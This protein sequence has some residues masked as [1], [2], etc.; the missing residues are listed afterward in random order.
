MQVIFEL[1]ISRFKRA[2]ELLKNQNVIAENILQ[3]P[4]VFNT[5]LGSI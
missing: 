3:L 1:M 4:H 2:C 5:S